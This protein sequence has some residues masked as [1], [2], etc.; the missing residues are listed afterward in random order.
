MAELE[1]LLHQS[2]AVI[3]LGSLIRNRQDGYL[4]RSE[5]QPVQVLVDGMLRSVP[6]FDSWG[7]V[8]V[9]SM[10][11]HPVRSSVLYVT[12]GDELVS[13]DLDAQ[14][15]SAVAIPDLCDVHEMTVIGDTLWLAN[16]G[17]DEILAFDT[18]RE[19]VSKRIRLNAYGSTSSN[20]SDVSGGSSE[21]EI[22]ERFH[23][24][25]VFEGFM[26][27]CTHWSTT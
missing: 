4:D 1:S 19:R 11:R 9:S 3:V 16:T 20:A 8:G 5:I 6:F 27:T 22:V 2:E 13:I 25:Q 26:E 15:V 21:D 14:C 10:A 24:N 7:E 18:V 12:N 17:S 23:C